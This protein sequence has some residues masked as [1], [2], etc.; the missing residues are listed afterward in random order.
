MAKSS[1]SAPASRLPSTRESRPALI[2]LA[3]LG[4]FVGTVEGMS[5]GILQMVL[6]QMLA[7]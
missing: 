6:R 4:L 3:V 2:G 7:T 5:G 1:S